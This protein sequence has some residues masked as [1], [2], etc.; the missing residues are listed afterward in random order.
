MHIPITLEGTKTVETRALIDSGAGGI[1]IDQKFLAQTNLQLETLEQPIT[2]YNVDGTRN[3]QGTISHF[4]RTTIRLGNTV[5]PIR[6]LVTGLGKETIILGLPWLQRV[7]PMIDWKNGTL[8][9][10]PILKPILSTMLRKSLQKKPPPTTPLSTIEEESEEDDPVDDEIED[11]DLIVAYMMGEPV[12]GVLRTAIAPLTPEYD[13]PTYFNARKGKTIGRLMQL[14]R[15]KRYSFTGNTWIQAKT[16]LAQDMEAKHKKEDPPKTLDE[17]LPPQYQEYRKVFE[18]EASERFPSSRI[19]DHAINLKPDF[20]PRSCKIYPL[21]P[22]EQKIQD[23]FLAEQQAKGYISPSDSPQASPFFFTGKK[24][25]TLRPCQ[26]YRYLNEGTIKNAYPLPL[27][28]ELVDKLEGA[29]IFTKL[30]LRWGYNNVRIKEGDQWKAAFKTN[31]GLFQPNVMFFGLCNSP[32]T[33]QAMMNDIFQDMMDEGWV[34]IYMDDILIF[35]DNIEDHRKRTLRVLQRLQENDLF[36][37]TEK[38]AFEVSEVEY[39]GMIIRPGQIAMDPKKLA[40]ISDWPVPNNVKGV[41][42]FLGFGNFYRRFIAGYSDLARPLNDLTKKDLPWA[43]TPV[44]QEAFEKLKAKFAEAPVLQIPNLTK[45]FLIE[46]DASK[47][48]SG[49]VIRQRDVNGEWHPCGY[50]SQSFD[51]TQRNYEIYDRELLGVVRGLKAWRHYLQGSPHP[52][53]VLSDHKNLTYFRN[54]QKLNTR[55]A[56]WS[57]FLSQFDLKLIHVPGTQMVQSDALSRRADLCPEDGNDNTDVILLPDYLFVNMIDADLHDAISK[58]TEEDDTVIEA[59]KALKDGTPPPLRSSLVDWKIEDGIVFY[60]GRCYVPAD[61]NLR[62]EI[63]KKYHDSIPAGHPGH[64]KTLEL[65]RRDYW[66]PGMY[67][68]TKQYVEGCA[69]CQQTKVNTHPTTPP[70]H[71]IKAPSNA[72]P[73]AQISMDF[74]TDLP[75]SQGFDSLLVVVDQGL[76]KGVILIPCNKTIDAIGTSKLLHQNVYRRFGLPDK[77]IS[78]RG[79][80]FAAATTLELGRILGIKIAL[81]TAYHPQTDGETERVNQETEAYLRIFCGNNPEKWSELLPNA[82]FAHNQR[83]HS[84]RNASPFYLLMGYHPKAVPTAYPRTNIPA[85]EQRILELQ[86][87]RDEAL[88]AHE[89]AR[90]RM[91]ERTTRGYKPFKKGERVWL[92]SRNLKIG[93]QTKKLAPRREGPFEVTEVLGPMTFKLKLPHQWKIHPVF[94]ASLLTPYRET[95]THGP[96]FHSP[97]PDLIDGQEEWEVEAILTHRRRRNRLEYLTTWKDYPSSDNSWEPEVAFENAQEIL[98]AYKRVHKL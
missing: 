21:T 10:P 5:L 81:S 59:L 91:I 36:L 17:L 30:D 39:L 77:I 60:K 13:G 58:A 24:D 56:R 75:L 38:C 83:I 18:K 54:A 41:R 2:V 40:G 20:I 31:R 50:I 74:V 42:S 15:S 64:Y 68:F 43:W 63:L 89:L 69:T 97:P 12:I 72:F 93:Y 1:F 4:V 52:T 44:C 61:I 98:N 35:S 66:W 92:D 53:T 16:T 84:A 26:D 9:I 55:Q 27:I 78:D 6:L 65:I 90:Q 19:Y 48:A 79:P 22:G 11:D 86:K 28:G 70:L 46:S 76:T 95:D 85:V 51:Q 7:N 8:S 82:E 80:Q 34:I 29:S 14:S 37:K 94:H 96:N 49:A 57:L 87:A 71:P 25:G 67:T 88:A 73:F 3:K 32:A 33:F 47:F 45:P 23:E 62:R